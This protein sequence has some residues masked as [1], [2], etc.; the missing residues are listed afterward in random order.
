MR[1]PRFA[2]PKLHSSI[3][4]SQLCERFVSVQN[5]PFPSLHARYT[6][7]VRLPAPPAKFSQPYSQ[8]CLGIQHTKWIQI[9]SAPF[10]KRCKGRSRLHTF[11]ENYDVRYKGALSFPRLTLHAQHIESERD[12]FTFA[13]VPFMSH[14]AYYASPDLPN[15]RWM[16]IVFEDGFSLFWTW[17]APSYRPEPSI[18][19]TT[20]KWCSL[21][22]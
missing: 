2:S 22:Q 5:Y 17:P 4:S 20:A 14:H 6:R 12:D 16:R 1:R 8:P 15:V 11:Y 10:A 18:V 19:S 21:L 7:A 3:A 9:S 13:R